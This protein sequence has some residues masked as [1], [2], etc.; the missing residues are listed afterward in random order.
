MLVDCNAEALTI[1]VDDA[2]RVSGLLQVPV[3]ARICFV[4]GQIEGV[5]WNVVFAW[6]AA[7]IF[8][9]DNWLAPKD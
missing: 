3:G 6:I 4:L 1:T 8:G 9:L 2:R 7:V 5:I